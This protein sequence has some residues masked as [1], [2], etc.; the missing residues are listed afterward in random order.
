MSKPNSNH[1][2]DNRNFKIIVIKMV[3]RGQYQK[4]L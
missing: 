1:R 2:W 4:E 3:M